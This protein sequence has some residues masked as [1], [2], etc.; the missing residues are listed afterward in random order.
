MAGGIFRSTVGIVRSAPKPVLEPAAKAFADAT[1]SPPYLYGMPPDEARTA[2]TDLQ[3]PQLLVPGTTRQRPDDANVTIF[4][5]EHVTGLLPVVLYLHGG[6]VFGDERTHGRLAREL[7]LG[8]GAAVV[9]VHYSR[10]PESRYPVAL[11]ECGAALDWVRAG[12]E[13]FGLDPSRIAVAGDSEGGALAAAL[14]LLDRHAL[15]GQVLLCPAT[16][17]ACDTGSHHEFAEG[18]F[19]RRDGMRWTWEQYTCSAE[20]RA[21]ITASP[22][23]APVRSLARLP[24][25]LV[26][27]AEADVLRDEGE[28]YA[29]RLR[30]AGV[31]VTA[32]R[33]QGIIHG[34][35]TLNALRGT[36]AAHSAIDQAGRFLARVLGG[37]HD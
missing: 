36:Q 23:R 30:E 35:V 34:F 28:A 18:Y 9:F 26:I 32:I 5:P 20:Q 24:P 2:V 8:A 1:A 4:R 11:K 22:L 16:D 31:Q 33:Y 10:S 19:L 15:A 12:G 7:A 3:H 14:C 21:E 25:T 29:A 37:G 6:W 13:A 27:T 17:A